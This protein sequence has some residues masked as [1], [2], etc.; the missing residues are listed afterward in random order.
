MLAK[1]KEQADA[2][3]LEARRIMILQ[4]AKETGEKSS[5]YKNMS[6]AVS[7]IFSLYFQ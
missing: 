3:E 2:D 6:F 5:I 4:N 1:S 7:Y